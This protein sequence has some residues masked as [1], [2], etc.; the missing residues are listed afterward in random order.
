MSISPVTIGIATAAFF[1]G[2]GIGFVAG[3]SSNGTR[4]SS[5]SAPKAALEAAPVAASLGNPTDRDATGALRRMVVS[6]VEPPFPQA[7]VTVGHC[8]RSAEAAGVICATKWTDGKGS[9]ARDRTIGFSKVGDQWVV[10]RW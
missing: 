6:G 4:S 9:P 8:E 7:T 1:V 10:S 5:E 2:C 3:S